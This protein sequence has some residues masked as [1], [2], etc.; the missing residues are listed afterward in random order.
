MMPQ[1]L[2][3]QRNRITASMTR[4]HRWEPPR[5]QVLSR[6]AFTVIEESLGARCGQLRITNCRGTDS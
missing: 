6:K 4:Y 5:E 2:E 1:R 3:R